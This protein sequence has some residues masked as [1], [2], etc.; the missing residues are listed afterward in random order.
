MFKNDYW[1]GKIKY[2]GEN[3]LLETYK[4]YYSEITVKGGGTYGKF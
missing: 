4:E 1:L 2:K 3:L